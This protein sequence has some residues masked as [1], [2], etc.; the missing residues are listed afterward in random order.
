[1]YVEHELGGASAHLGLLKSKT[2]FH[3]TFSIKK[4]HNMQLFGDVDNK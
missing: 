1:M 4:A 3:P 2:H